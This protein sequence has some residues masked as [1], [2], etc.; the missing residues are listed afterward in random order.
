LHK[1]GLVIDVIAW[2]D[3]VLVSVPA[4]AGRCAS[5]LDIQKSPCAVSRVRRSI[6]VA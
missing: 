6:A 3:Q 2:F 4:T 1:P 5:A